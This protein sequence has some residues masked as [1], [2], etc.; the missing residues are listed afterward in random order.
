MSDLAGPG[1]YDSGEVETVGHL[2]EDLG[3]DVPSDELRPAGGG[4]PGPADPSVS[5]AD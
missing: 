4:R 2:E 5:P 3:S 1:A